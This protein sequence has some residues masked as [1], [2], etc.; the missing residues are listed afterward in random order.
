MAGSVV[1]R[2]ATLG[3]LAGTAVA[4]VAALLWFWSSRAV[5]PSVEANAALDRWLNHSCSVGEGTGVED[6]LRGFG[7][8]LETPL[9]DLFE[10]GPAASEIAQVEAAARRQFERIRQVINSGT[11]TGLP[12]DQAKALLQIS[13]Q[14]F[15]RRAREDYIDSRKEAALTG[16][17]LTGG[18]KGRRLLERIA[19]DPKSPYRD[20]ARLARYGDSQP[21]TN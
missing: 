7:E 10:K 16:L 20:I 1:S 19:A 18:S 13:L 3:F 17:A 8:E 9:I 4:V 11:D 5:V 15:S 14:E 6:A 21:S 2:S 12:A